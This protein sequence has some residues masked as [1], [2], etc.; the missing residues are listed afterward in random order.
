MKSFKGFSGVLFADH[1]N[2]ETFKQCILPSIDRIW[3][4]HTV[5]SFAYGHTGSGKTYTIMGYDEEKSPGM[6][7]QTAGYIEVE[8]KRIN[9]GIEEEADQLLMS[10]RFA[11]L[12]QGKMR[13][14]FGNLVE[15]HVR[16]SDSGK[17]IIR[18]PT[19][20][21]AETGQVKVAPLTPVMVGEG[22][23]DNFL[24]RVT[25]SLALRKQGSSA[26]HDES[27]RSH[28]FL[29]MELVTRRLLEA[30]TAL[31]N[32][33]AEIVPIGKALT[34]HRIANSMFTNGAATFNPETK[35]FEINEEWKEDK[36]VTKRLDALT[37]E[38]LRLSVQIIGCEQRLE[39]TMAASHSS[40]GGKV[41]FVDLAGNEWGSD[42][43][44]I[45]NDH[46]IQ[47]KERQE[48]NK[49]LLALKESVRAINL[50][51]DHV[52]FRDSKLTM[53]MRPHL[54]ADHSTAI[55]IANISPSE[56]HIKKTFNTLSYSAMVAKA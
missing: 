1:D 46:G 42:S 40:I 16:E 9:E 3:S 34:D 25:Q 55:M 36:A 17:I 14:L 18:G 6:Y 8:M 23:L 30:R 24:R 19:L 31:W 27:S 39:S 11:E 51:R 7:R 43:K 50:K 15:C 54:M 4:G 2:R 56:Q 33:E 29:E 32:A 13:D 52:P 53:V 48:I 20:I 38:F 10:C 37:D 49:S 35:E 26:V 41:V 12:Y 28:V 45:R 47:K 44:N 22:E 21:D 5:C